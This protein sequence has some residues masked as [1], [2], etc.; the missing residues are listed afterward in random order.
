M[1]KTHLV[2][3]L[4][5]VGLLTAVGLFVLTGLSD[6]DG[7]SGETD[8]L[9][10][11]SGGA[12]LV[13]TLVRPAG[14]VDPPIAL[15]VHGDG[16]QTR[17]S[18]DAYLPLVNSL[19]DAGI[20]VFTWDKPG[21]GR[22]SGNWLE[23]SMEDRAAEALAALARVVSVPGV[24]ADKVGFLGFSQ[25]GWV[26]PKA[27]SRREPAFSILVGPAVNWRRQGAYYTRKRLEQAGLDGEEVE[28]QVGGNLRANDAIFGTPG[29]SPDPTDRPDLDPA[30]FGFV[31]RNYAEDATASLGSMRGPVLAVWGE[32][33]SNV[34]P[35]WNASA[36]REALAPSGDR[37]V[38]VLAGATHGLLRASLFDYQLASDWPAWSE[39]AFAMAGRRAY[40]PGA[41]D[42]IRDWIHEVTK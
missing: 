31:A 7:A 24:T 22:S 8:I 34:D 40:A 39:A 12:T 42:L 27:A 4:G 13:G 1:L 11:P 36:Y 23:Q 28:R 16:P 37:Q 18:N 20:G 14:V 38:V 35:V 26:L 10:F 5:T 17:F 15:L 19:L 6:F 41:L 9:S 3:L 32:R 33:D 30:R 2:W 21:V 29:E 25:A